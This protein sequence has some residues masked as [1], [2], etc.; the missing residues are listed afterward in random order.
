MSDDGEACLHYH[1]EQ[2]RGDPTL[3]ITVSCAQ[4]HWP[5]F[6]DRLEGRIY[7]A[8]GESVDLRADATRRHQAVQD[9]AHLAQEFPHERLSIYLKVA[10]T[11]VFGVRHYRYMFECAKSR[12]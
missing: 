9:Y 12:G 2:G 6:L 5:E 10:L 8:T 11:P 7:I 3:F 4:F 1:V